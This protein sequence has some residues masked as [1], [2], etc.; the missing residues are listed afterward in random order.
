MN[1]RIIRFHFYIRVFGVIG[2]L[3][4]SWLS[5]YRD[6]LPLLMFL[7][8]IFLT[9]ALVAYKRIGIFSRI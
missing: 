8:A 2:V 9:Y 4:L 5:E 7:S 1:D 3:S 6:N